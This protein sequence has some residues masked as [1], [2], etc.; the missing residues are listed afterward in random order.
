MQTYDNALFYFST[1]MNDF[2]R[3][4]YNYAFDIGLHQ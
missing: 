2:K 1:M 3:Y 4:P